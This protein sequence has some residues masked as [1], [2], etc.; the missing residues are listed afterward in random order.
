M[1]PAHCAHRLFGSGAR[2]VP[3][4]EEARKLIRRLTGLIRPKARVLADCSDE[5]RSLLPEKGSSE[6]TGLLRD[7]DQD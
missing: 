5:V 2:N 4:P 1:G 3:Q 7:E 6:M